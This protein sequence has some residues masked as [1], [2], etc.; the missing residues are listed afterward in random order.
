MT[1]RLGNIV[2]INVPLNNLREMKTLCVLRALCVSVV[3]I[4]LNRST[5]EAQSSQRSHRDLGCFP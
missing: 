3:V 5:T 2:T 4:L 1:G